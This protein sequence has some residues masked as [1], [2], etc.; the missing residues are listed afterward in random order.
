MDEIR[1]RLYRAIS[2]MRRQYVPLSG[3][4]LHVGSDVMDEIKRN[5]LPYEL[6]IP[7]PITSSPWAFWG[8]PVEVHLEEPGLFELRWTFR[9]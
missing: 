2:A 5:A 7:D 3:A 4:R 1:E 8:I 6:G 9:V